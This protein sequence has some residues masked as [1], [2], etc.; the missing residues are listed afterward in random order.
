MKTLLLPLLAGCA[1]LLPVNSSQ[2]AGPVGKTYGGFSPGK[3]FTL[4]VTER[5]S[6]RTKG[7]DADKDVP[8]PA[9]WPD[10]QE[11]QKVKFTIGSKGQ[12]TGPGFSITFRDEE[13]RVNTYSNNPSLSGPEGEA[14]TV[15]KNR[16]D[17]PR[18]ATLTFYKLRFSGLIPIT[19][20]V[21]YEFKRNP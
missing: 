13:G 20:T 9:G 11:G 6:V 8:V 10:F 3:T 12:L 4:T 16:N 19:N 14:A 7:D 15:V 17:K 21:N 1:A 2:A 18:R 5:S